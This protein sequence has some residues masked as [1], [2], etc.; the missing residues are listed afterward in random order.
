[1][2]KKSAKKASTKRSSKSHTANLVKAEIPFALLGAAKVVRSSKIST[3]PKRNPEGISWVWGSVEDF[4]PSSYRRLPRL[5]N[6]WPPDDIIALVKLVC[7][8]AGLAGVAYKLIKLWFESRNAKRIRIKRGDYE[9]EIQ[10]SM[11]KTEIERRVTQFRALTKKLDK[12]EIKVILPPSVDK[13]L[14]SE[15]PVRKDEKE[16]NKAKIRKDNRRR[17]TGQFER[18]GVTL[19]LD[20][21]LVFQCDECGAVWSPDVQKGGRLLHNYWHCPNGC[22]R[23]KIGMAVMLN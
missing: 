23:P 16:D 9:L 6:P 15:R 14:P 4:E 20:T 1:M 2:T 13:S 21:P 19:L 22:N 8:T 7:S 5:P 18:A 11:S 12:D 17:A 3:R 10:G